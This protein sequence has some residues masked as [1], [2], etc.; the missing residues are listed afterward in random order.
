MRF[1]TLHLFAHKLTIDPEY[2]D[3]IYTPEELKPLMEQI[4]S[5]GRDGLSS[6]VFA[7][8]KIT[9]AVSLW[10]PV[11]AAP[12]VRGTAPAWTANPA[13]FRIPYGT[14]LNLWEETSD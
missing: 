2:L 14:L 11:A 9:P 6:R 5:E 3:K 7:M 1:Q 4:F 10:P 12:N 13:A 8:E